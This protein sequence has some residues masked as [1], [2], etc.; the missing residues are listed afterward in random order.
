MAIKY[1]VSSLGAQP[2]IYGETEYE[3]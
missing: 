2:L 3:D 1:L